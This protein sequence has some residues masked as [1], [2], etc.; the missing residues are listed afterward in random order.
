MIGVIENSIKRL[1]QGLEDGITG[2]TITLIT[3]GDYTVREGGGGGRRD[4]R[5]R[6]LAADSIRF[7]TEYYISCEGEENECNSDAGS[8]YSTVKG[9]LT[10]GFAGTSFGVAVSNELDETVGLDDGAWSL[11]NDADPL[12]GSFSA[13]DFELLGGVTAAPSAA[14][15]GAPSGAPSAASGGNGDK[16]GDR[17]GGGN[18]EVELKKEGGMPKFGF[19]I[20]F[21]GFFGTCGALLMILASYSRYGGGGGGGSGGGGGRGEKDSYDNEYESSEFGEKNPIGNDRL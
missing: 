21:A 3:V 2:I 14:P 8:S 5:R 11:L 9:F 1:I 18:D 13:S 12:G 4:L 15:S 16:D 10:D 7:L 20:Y 19:E 17:G 6:K